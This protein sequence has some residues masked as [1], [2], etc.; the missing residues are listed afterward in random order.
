[1]QVIAVATSQDKPGMRA[2]P[3]LERPTVSA[4][5]PFDRMIHRAKVPP[6]QYGFVAARG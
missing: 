1:M 5:V 6:R 4:R 3:L 2:I